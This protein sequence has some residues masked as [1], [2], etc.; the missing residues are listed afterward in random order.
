MQIIFNIIFSVQPFLLSILI[1]RPTLLKILISNLNS[2]KYIIE[3]TY[4]LYHI[5]TT[6]SFIL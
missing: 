3:V 4:R 6:L 1:P 2:Y 5:N